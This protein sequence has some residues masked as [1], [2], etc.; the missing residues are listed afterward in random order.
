MFR[1]LRHCLAFALCVLA[2]PVFARTW[3]VRQGGRD[4]ADGATPA[5]A[6][7]TLS[8]AAQVLQHGDR[9]ILGPGSYRD[10]VF[11]AERSGTP[12]ARLSLLGDESGTLTGDPAGAV[13]LAPL[14][15]DDPALCLRQGAHLTV[16]GL[17]LRGHGLGVRFERCKDVVVTRCTFDGFACGLATKGV[18]DFDLTSCVFAR[19]VIGASLRA[20]SRTRIEHVTAASCSTAGVLLA[21]CGPGRIRNG[22][23]A[24]NAAGFIADECSAQNWSSDYNALS[25]G[26][27]PWGD[28]LGI[29]F[30]YQW[31][32]ASGQDRHSL[33]LTPTFA[34]P[35]HYDLHIAAAVTWAGGLPGMYVGTP[36]AAPVLDRDGHPFRVRQGTVSVGA[37][38]YPEPTPG[39]GW[40]K[41]AVSLK[42]AGPRQSAGLYQPDGTLVRML[43]T[44]VTGVRDLWW[45]GHDDLGQ[46]A[47][48]GKYQVRSVAHDVRLTD[49]GAVGNS[50]NAAG[51]YNPYNPMR[52]V[53]L[54]D[55]GFFL[56]GQSEHGLAMR[57]YSASGQPRNASF[58]KAMSYWGL[59]TAGDDIIGGYVDA[60][61]TPDPA[62]AQLVRLTQAGTRALMA[63]GARAY[64]IFAA[65]EKG[66][67]PGG[68]AVVGT[69][70]YV[71]VP[72]L[73][74]V[75]LLDLTTGKPVADWLLPGVA[76]ITADDTGQLWAVAGTDVV[77]LDRTGAVTRRLPTGLPTPR[78]LSVGQ[79]L[80]AVLDAAAVRIVVLH[81]ADGHTVRACGQAPTVG[82]WAPM[83]V[84]TLRNPAGVTVLAD[85]RVL[86]LESHRVRAFWPETGTIAFDASS[87]FAGPVVTHPARS[88]YAYSPEGIF[89][90][91]PV[92]GAWAWV[93]EI[94]FLRHVAPDDAKKA[95][96]YPYAA[97]LLDGRPFLLCAMGRTG[98]LQ[99][100]DVTDPVQPRVALIKEDF[101]K[102]IGAS[103]YATFGPH[104]DLIRHGTANPAALEL[105]TIK[106]QGLDAAKNPVYDFAHPVIVGPKKDP[107]ARGLQWTWGG[108]HRPV[109]DPR[110]G[111]VYHL[112]NTALYPVRVA[113]FRGAT[114]VAKSDAAGHPLWYVNG[115]DSFYMGLDCVD[116]GKHAWVFAGDWFV[117]GPDVFDDD[118]LWITSGNVS[119]PSANAGGMMDIPFAAVSANV[120]PDG[121][122]GVNIEDDS[123]SRSIHLRLEGA[124]TLRKTITLLTWKT[125]AATPAPAP[126]PSVPGGAHLP[127]LLIPKVKPLAVDGNWEAWRAAGGTAQ[128]LNLPCNV[129][130]NRGM[131]E[132]LML[133]LSDC[134]SLGGIVH[135]DANFYVYFLVADATLQLEAAHSGD[136]YAYDGIE[137][138]LEQEQF[139]M[140]VL[141][142]GTPDLHKHRQH[143]RDKTNYAGRYQMP[144][145]DVWATPLDDLGAHPLG[146]TLAAMTGISM[147]GK[148]GYAVM[149]KIPFAEIKLV[150]GVGHPE[151]IT[152]MTGA[153]GEVVRAIVSQAC[154]F[155]W[156]SYQDAKISWPPSQCFFD[157]NRSIPLELE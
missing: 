75:R 26:L 134:T 110:T 154:V 137:F 114:G 40:Q 68:L 33:Y 139:T 37:Y 148:K 127:Y 39:P 9:V 117:G 62:T 98:G 8:R 31:P 155:T 18:E 157:A 94:P 145:E 6:F 11:I 84:D 124:E 147:T 125:A 63:S 30:P 153:P 71:A 102:L 3:Y 54:P 103:A 101:G 86:I 69:T 76:D 10:T 115:D 32:S 93:A 133:T 151:G 79:G 126:Q 7:H 92:T 121:K 70:A 78:N 129:S 82:M 140:G 12:E 43:L 142:D 99:L 48:A 96:G 105:A 53:A 118:G 29:G 22:I 104:G 61:Q 136:L 52:A 87:I 57:R 42:G 47:A 89:H 141:K 36:G 150:G 46:P 19:C 97:A 2:L 27:G 108:E 20:T 112:A 123:N 35:A 13:V 51:F 58:F 130:F 72:A 4:Q 131:P 109:A 83:S 152:D 122:V 60:A 28:V 119:W 111:D 149:A 156:G 91:D 38:D 95:P 77:A 49:A 16:S 14:T 146:Q 90:L 138:F 135:D 88:D 56:Y 120:T 50:G 34:D 66:G 45:D 113:Y 107:T 17:T 67:V 55:G 132:D 21:S 143:N 59:A 106:F 80:L 65:G 44:N 100:V 74:L 116:D 25:G 1:I 64:P 81:S 73:N 5:T 41:L 144:A 128:I 85:G 23:F 15:A 24:Q